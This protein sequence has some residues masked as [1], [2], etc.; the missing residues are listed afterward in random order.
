MALTN[1]KVFNKT[2]QT[3][4]TEKLAQDVEKFNAASG[5]AI[6][7]TADGFE[8]DY[9]YENFWAGLHAA[10][11][12][13]D[14]YA[15]NAAASATNLAQLQ[16]IGV[17]VA[18]GFG[19]I[20]WEPGQLAW[21]QKSPAEAAAVVSKYLAEAILKDQL[22]SAIAALVGAIEAGTTNTVFDANTG[23]ITYADLNSAHALF[24]DQSGLIIANVMDG[25]TYHKFI[26]QNIANAGTLFDY[27]GVRV[28]DIL[29]RRVV[30]TDAPAL[31]ESPSTA[32]NDAKV[33]G[34]VQGA[35]TVYDGSDLIT[36]LQ[37]TNGKER[38]E[39]TWQADY[40]FGLALKGFA[41][42][43]ANG[44]KSPTDAEIATGS[45]WD[46]VATSW[47]NTAGVMVTGITTSS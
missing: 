22:N 20:A 41:W 11:R 30:V 3:M 27:Q 32:A 29:G 1:M 46:K 21:V 47:K 34:L 5:G 42:D 8:G 36:N 19:P 37:T 25:V 13:V 18:G 14:R 4:A 6:T 23:P 2:V 7:L 40:T 44:G 15:T 17:K 28:V 16:A 33:L 45:N 9:R 35:A 43:T 39:T 24:G 31:R 38:I 12:R 10:Q 26:G